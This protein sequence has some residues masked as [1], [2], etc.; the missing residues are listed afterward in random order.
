MYMLQQSRRNVSMLTKLVSAICIASLF[1]SGI[2]FA[3]PPLPDK[4]ATSALV[5]EAGVVNIMT[6]PEKASF[7]EVG[8]GDI[9]IKPFAIDGKMSKHE[10]VTFVILPVLAGILAAANNNDW[11]GTSSS[12]SSGLAGTSDGQTFNCGVLNSGSGDVNCDFSNTGGDSS[13]E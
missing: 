10:L 6:V 1:G 3:A 8:N 7:I 4:E 2:A 13:G 11:L 12:S 9:G 5:E